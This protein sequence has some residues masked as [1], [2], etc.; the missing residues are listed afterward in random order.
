MHLIHIDPEILKS[1]F[2]MHSRDDLF[3]NY[4]RDP[5]SYKISHLLKNK[6]AQNKPPPVGKIFLY[7]STIPCSYP[8]RLSYS[9]EFYLLN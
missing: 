1:E 5:K 2:Q 3:Y 9:T 4:F 6:G 7:L 8:V